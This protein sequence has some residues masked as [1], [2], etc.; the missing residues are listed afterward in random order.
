MFGQK[1]MFQILYILC[2]RISSELYETWNKL[3]TH[4]QTFVIQ[5]LRNKFKP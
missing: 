2:G 3:V 1:P 5:Y 4:V